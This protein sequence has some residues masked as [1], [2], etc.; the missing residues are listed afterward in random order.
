VY[1]NWKNVPSALGLLGDARLRVV[2]VRQEHDVARVLDRLMTIGITSLATD[3]TL[4]AR[5]K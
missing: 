4:P 5:E 3:S 2:L 1:A